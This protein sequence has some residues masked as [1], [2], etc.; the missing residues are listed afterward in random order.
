[1]R[2]DFDENE[3]Y[4]EYI[5]YWFSFQ[6]LCLSTLNGNWLS[7][8]KFLGK[9]VAA[10]VSTCFLPS[11]RSYF[12]T[13]KIEELSLIISEYQ[14]NSLRFTKLQVEQNGDVTFLDLQS[15]HHYSD[16]LHRATHAL[17]SNIKVLNSLVE[18]SRD[19]QPKDSP[20]LANKYEFFRKILKSVVREQTFLQS[21]AELVCNRAERMSLMVCMHSTEPHTAKVSCPC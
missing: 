14:Q 13:E 2:E 11:R 12:P 19:I 18:E 3:T 1:M 21:H 15:L 17:K 7:Y 16:L 20:D 9:K 5:D 4:T 6:L 8:I 10:V